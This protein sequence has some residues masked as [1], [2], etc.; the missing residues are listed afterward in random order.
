MPFKRE[1]NK[2][3]YAAISSG[4]VPVAKLVASLLKS[5]RLDDQLRMG[6]L[7]TE[8]PKVMGSA[9]AAHTRA[10]RLNG[11]ELVVFVDNSVWLSELYRSRAQM[12]A[13]LQKA[14]GKSRIRR[15]RLQLDPG[16]SNAEAR[17]SESGTDSNPK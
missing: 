2:S 6:R 9:V 16:N 8:W 15:L 1:S 10:G 17:I 7:E 5:M 13:N 12:L 11:D 4:G 14:F 3:H